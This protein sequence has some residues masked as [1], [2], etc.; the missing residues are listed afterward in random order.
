MNSR[1]FIRPL[2][3]SILVDRRNIVARRQC[4][5]QIAIAVEERIAAD[6]G[7][8]GPASVRS[9]MAVMSLVGQSRRFGHVRFTSD[10][11]DS[12]VL[13]GHDDSAKGDSNSW[14]DGR[15]VV[16]RLN[17]LDALPRFSSFGKLKL[18]TY[19]PISGLPEIGLVSA[20]VE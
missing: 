13:T 2:A 9:A 4:N 11:Y 20:Q 7:C 19:A 16:S 15:F 18:G 14:S 3:V 17:G 1:R 10:R 8:A 5:D 12:G 6:N